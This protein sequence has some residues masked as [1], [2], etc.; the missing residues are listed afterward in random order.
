MQPCLEV[1]LSGLIQ[2]EEE[3]AEMNAEELKDLE[4]RNESVNLNLNAKCGRNKKKNTNVDQCAGI[5]MGM[6]RTILI[7]EKHEKLKIIN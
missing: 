2:Y 6:F 3:D 5:L 7:E 4:N 1:D